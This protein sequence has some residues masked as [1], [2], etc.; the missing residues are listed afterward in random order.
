MTCWLRTTDQWDVQEEVKAVGGMLK[1]RNIP[2]WM[3]IDGCVGGNRSA[4]VLAVTFEFTSADVLF[5]CTRI[6][7]A[8]A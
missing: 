5:V 4:H 2:V 6:A 3:D 8:G 1:A 7:A